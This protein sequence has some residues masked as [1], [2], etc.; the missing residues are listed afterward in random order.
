MKRVRPTIASKL[1]YETLN[2]VQDGGMAMTAW[3]EAVFQGESPTRG[4]AEIDRQLRDYC[5]LNTLAMV[6]LRQMLSGRS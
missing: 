1:G 2:G 5:K 3:M 4:K 6:R